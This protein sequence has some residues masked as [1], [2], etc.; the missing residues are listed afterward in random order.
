MPCLSTTWDSKF[1]AAGGYCDPEFLP[2]RFLFFN[3]RVRAVSKCC[4]GL[5]VITGAGLQKKF[6]FRGFLGGG[7]RGALL[8]SRPVGPNHVFSSCKQDFNQNITFGILILVVDCGFFFFFW[9]V[10][11]SLGYRPHA[12]LSMKARSTTWIQCIWYV[13]GP[14]FIRNG[15]TLYFFVFFFRFSCLVAEV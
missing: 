4:H 9:R 5:Q 7:F 8:A 10:G 14:D 12:N 15:R 2:V 3:F 11:R 13:F 6:L 1:V